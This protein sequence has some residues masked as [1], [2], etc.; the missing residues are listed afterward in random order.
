MTDTYQDRRMDD[1]R[2]ASACPCTVCKGNG[3]TR[4]AVRTFT[5]N[6][7]RYRL[8]QLHYDQWVKW[9]VFEFLDDLRESGVTNMF[10]AAPYISSTYPF[11]SKAS[12]RHLL[13]EWMETFSER[14]GS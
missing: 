11:I 13:T 3:K 7:T 14:N 6:G 9:E 12:A 5:H 10:G 8:C 4:E 1:R 2:L